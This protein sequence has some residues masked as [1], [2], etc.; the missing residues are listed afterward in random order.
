MVDECLSAEGHF[1]YC[2][3]S[4]FL[5]KV[6]VGAVGL[7]RPRAPYSRL[8][9]HWNM[10]KLWAFRASKRRYGMRAPDLYRA[11]GK[12]GI[13]NVIMVLL[14]RAELPNL[15]H[16]ERCY[17]RLLS[18]VFNVLG[19]AGEDALPAAVK[20]VLGSSMSEDI[21]LVA[22]ALLRK[23]RPPP[24]SSCLA[25]VGGAGAEDRGQGADFQA[26]KASAAD[27]SVAV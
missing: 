4:P 21:R 6:Y 7:K 14:A 24:S 1:V 10:V 17:I 27:L 23:N 5:R 11:A 26:G 9:E 2:L 19:V 20:R 3:L 16:V 22:S 18:P 15:A 12:V 8:R 13:G 25:S